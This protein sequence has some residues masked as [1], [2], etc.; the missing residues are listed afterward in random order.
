MSNGDRFNLESLR[1]S[2]APYHKRLEQSHRARALMSSDVTLDDVVGF[3]RS[4]ST[5][6]APVIKGWRLSNGEIS[7]YASEKIKELSVW[8]GSDWP[9][10]GVEA[11]V[12]KNQL[13]DLSFRYVVLGSELGQQSVHKHLASHNLIDDQYFCRSREVAIP[14]FRSVLKRIST[15]SDGDTR[16]LATKIGRI[17]DEISCVMCEEGPTVSAPFNDFVEEKSSNVERKARLV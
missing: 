10:E 2:I 1:A 3:Y 14:L 8:V 6:F 13:D 9:F 15:L 17:F 5:V 11:Y 12:V 16:L 7:H 4:L